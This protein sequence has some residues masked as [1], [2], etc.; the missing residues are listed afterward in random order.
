MIKTKN[1]YF[2]DLQ[3]ALDSIEYSDSE[4]VIELD[5]DTY[6]G[7]FTVD[8]PNITIMGN[9]SVI[10]GSLYGHEILD[11]GYKRGTFNTYTLF[12]DADNV[13]LYDLCIM[14]NA[15]YGKDI[16][17]AIALMSNGDNLRVYNCEIIS[18]Q[19][20]LFIGPLPEKEIEPGGFKGPMQNK[21]R[22]HITNYFE[23]TYISG[24][25][26]FI[27]GSGSAYFNSCVLYSRNINAEINGYVC[28]PSTI[29][30]YPGFIF[31]YCE[32]LSDCKDNSVY[33]ARPWRNNAKVY[34]KNSYIGKHI[35]PEGYHDWDKT[36]ARNTVEF[37]EE[38]NINANTPERVS[39]A[40]VIK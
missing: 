12:I 24:S 39:W 37:V 40:K 27:F 32:F 30:E 34:I 25:I 35:K 7:Q 11:D 17:Q 5:N 23:D 6:Y 29:K 38:N 22:R 9:G 26:D 8:K 31:N 4:T 3:E 20:T 36:E 14:N 33:L 21:E 19:D 18:Y 10:T 1:K 28:A 16:G 13:K 2:T 15:G